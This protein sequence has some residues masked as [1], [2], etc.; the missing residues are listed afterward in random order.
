MVHLNKL[1]TLDDTL[2]QLEQQADKLQE[3]SNAYEKL[4]LLVQSY[5][6]IKVKFGKNNQVLEQF[7]DKQLDSLKNF[8]NTQEKSFGDFIIGQETTRGEFKKTLAEIEYSNVENQEILRTI[9]VRTRKALI[10][11]IDQLRVA[12]KGF[13]IDMEQSLRIKLTENE[14]AVKSLIE[15]GQEKQ[16][17][18]LIQELNRQN[19]QIFDRQ[20]NMTT[21]LYVIGVLLFFLLIGLVYTLFV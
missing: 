11:E 6:E 19:K 5:E 4:T 2:S 14:S 16:K 12:N 8:I 10:G 7:A 18:I 9:N 17:E 20:K 1:K 15:T 3:T 13:Y 21:I